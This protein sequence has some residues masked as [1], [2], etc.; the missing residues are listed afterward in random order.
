MA[1]TDGRRVR[2]LLDE[3]FVMEA[4]EIAFLSGGSAATRVLNEAG[5]TRDGTAVRP[6]CPCSFYRSAPAAHDRLLDFPRLKPRI[7]FFTLLNTVLLAG[8]DRIGG[9]DHP[10]FMVPEEI[11]AFFGM[12]DRDANQLFGGDYPVSKMVQVARSA[13]GSRELGSVATLEAARS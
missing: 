4:A 9:D 10:L 8:A 1:K 6:E 11:E 2:E 5:W 12:H 13:S 3:G 7:Q